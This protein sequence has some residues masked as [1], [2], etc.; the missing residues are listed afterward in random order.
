M[1]RSNRCLASFKSSIRRL[2]ASRSP[3][4]RLLRALLLQAFYSIRLERQ[5]VERIDHD[6]LFRWF[7]GLGI[8]D[9]VW[10]ATTFTKNR[11]RL[12]EGDVAAQFLA[13]VLAQDKSLPR[14]RCFVLERWRDG[15]RLWQA[16]CWLRERLMDPMGETK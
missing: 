12:L 9:P 16:V 13:A 1:P 4:E 3:P 2:A 10:D 15:A 5:L 7:V 11:D 14:R 6:L 8:E